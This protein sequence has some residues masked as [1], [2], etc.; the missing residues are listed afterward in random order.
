MYH[1]V[2]ELENNQCSSSSSSNSS[3]VDLLNVRRGFRGAGAVAPA[4][5]SAV[6]SDS[7]GWTGKTPRSGSHEIGSLSL[8]MEEADD[9]DG[10]GDPAPMPSLSL[11][12]RIFSG[13][14][15]DGRSRWPAPGELVIFF[16]A[17][18]YQH[19][20]CIYEGLV[21]C[22]VERNA[23][24]IFDDVGFYIFDGTL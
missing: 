24:F 10:A 6:F 16:M 1:P 18:S 9:G 21:L 5:A 13:G 19:Y 4:M 22:C 2:V 20:V 8:S 23:F 14:G 15:A 11:R 12:G 7:V 3:V 17:C